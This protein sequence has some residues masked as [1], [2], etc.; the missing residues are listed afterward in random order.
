LRRLS[1]ESSPAGARTTERTPMPDQNELASRY[2]A[3]NAALLRCR[4]ASMAERQRALDHAAVLFSALIQ[5]GGDQGDE[6][7]IR[8]LERLGMSTE[9]AAQVVLAMQQ[10]QTLVDLRNREPAR[11][12]RAE[13]QD[14]AEL[15]D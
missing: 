2:L 12:A 3:L 14:Q 5:E 15:G 9:R 7:L 8:V 4:C 11:R 1:G 10:D 6:G 13:D